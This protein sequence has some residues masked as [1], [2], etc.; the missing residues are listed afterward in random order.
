CRLRPD[1]ACRRMHRGKRRQRLRGDDYLR[2]RGDGRGVSAE[3]NAYVRV[4]ELE[5]GESVRREEFGQLAQFVHV[6]CGLGAALLGR[7]LFLSAPASSP[8]S[9]SA[10][11]ARLGLRRGCRARRA[12]LLAAVRLRLVLIA[13]AH[14]LPPKFSRAE[15][16][17]ARMPRFQM[18]EKSPV[19]ACRASRAR[20]AFLSRAF[21]D[22]SVGSALEIFPLRLRRRA[23]A[24][25]CAPL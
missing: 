16:T 5:V 12:G 24:R 14:P 8:V 9:R 10:L 17:R 21:A 19:A 11:R 20:G 25:S 3:A 13:R 1:R 23:P 7:S 4:L 6:E 22:L 2:A 18:Q 15:R